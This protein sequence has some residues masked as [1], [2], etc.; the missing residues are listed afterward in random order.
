[1]ANKQSES[2]GI[3]ANDHGRQAAVIRPENKSAGKKM[4]ENSQTINIF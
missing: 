4:K 1:L 3:P 2:G